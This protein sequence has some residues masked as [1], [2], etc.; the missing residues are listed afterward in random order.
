MKHLAVLFALLAIT[1]SAAIAKGASS[2]PLITVSGEGVVTR[3]PDLA[4]VNI[5]IETNADAASTALSDNN[6]R[7]GDL[8]N[9]MHALGIAESDI[10]AS[11]YN[12][13]YNPPQPLSEGT[14]V[15]RPIP[16]PNQ[17][18]SG[19]VVTRTISV[20]VRKVNEAGKVIDESI[21]AGATNVN[22]VEFSVSDQR[23]TYAAALRAAVE[24]AQSQARAMAAA[25]HMRIVRIRSMQSGYFP[26]PVM[27]RGAAQTADA[28]PR[29]P[30]VVKP[31]NLDV[32][33][34]VTIVYEMGPG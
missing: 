18:R 32:R 17:Q 24:D 15:G 2:A 20:K 14:T 31:E 22:G 4:T 13:S 19:Y 26:A 27:M 34:N 7:F 6:R 25:A 1:G 8:K 21:A 10:N 3:S 11:T 16:F 30:T 29:V 28:Y 5:S 23:G 9:R 12:V 33:A